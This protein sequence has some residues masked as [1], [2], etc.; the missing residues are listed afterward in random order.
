MPDELQTKERLRCPAVV[1]ALALVARLALVLRAQSVRSRAGRLCLQLATRQSSA[2]GPP[3]VL[4]RCRHIRD[5]RT[6]G[7]SESENQGQSSAYPGCVGFVSDPS[8]F[9]FFRIRLEAV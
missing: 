3:E 9:W 2:A 8:R 5:E 1:P 4:Q 7:R 6:C